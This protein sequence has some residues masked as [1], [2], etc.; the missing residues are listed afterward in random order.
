M[1][2][3]SN[4]TWFVE[5]DKR[6][7]LDVMWTWQVF[8]YESLHK[9]RFKGRSSCFYLTLIWNWRLTPNSANRWTT[10]LV[11]NHIYWFVH[12]SCFSKCSISSLRVKILR[13]D[14]RSLSSK[15]YCWCLKHVRS[16]H[17]MRGQW[18]RSGYCT[19]KCLPR[20]SVYILHGHF[21]QVFKFT[22]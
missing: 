1:S 12:V 18:V 7:K 8:S 6:L 21:L 22:P 9:I 2:V 20:T 5:E 4:W 17:N 19:L 16:W 11:Q 3:L 14:I 13:Y 10:V 15:H